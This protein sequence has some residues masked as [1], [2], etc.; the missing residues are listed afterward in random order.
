MELL[1]PRHKTKLHIEHTTLS[2]MGVAYPAVTGKCEKCRDIYV[3]RG[4]SLSNRRFNLAGVSYE[5][6]SELES[7]YPAQPSICPKAEKKNLVTEVSKN[8]Q[9]SIAPTLA[10]KEN[11]IQ[12]NRNAEKNQAK[13]VGS[14]ATDKITKETTKTPK[15]KKKKSK[16]KEKSSV[17]FTRWKFVYPTKE[18]TTGP[19]VTANSSKQ[20][21]VSALDIYTP[22]TT[23]EMEARGGTLPV[24]QKPTRIFPTEITTVHLASETDK[25]FWITI[26]GDSTLQESPKGILWSERAICKAILRAIKNKKPWV[27]YNSEP[28]QIVSYTNPPALQNCLRNFDKPI[29]TSVPPQQEMKQ[30]EIAFPQPSVTT[31]HKKEQTSGSISALDLV[32]GVPFNRKDVIL[33][34]CKGLIA[35]KRDN[36]KVIAATGLL[37]GRRNATA[38]IN[39]NYCPQCNKCFIGYDEYQHY[40]KQYKILIGNIR[41]VSNKAKFSDLDLAEESPLHLCG[42]S[43]SQS[44]GLTVTER[45]SILQY[46]MEYEIMQKPYIID[47]LNFFIRRNGSKAD[48]DIAVQKWRDDLD[49]VRNYRLGSQSMFQIS[50]VKKNR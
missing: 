6:M 14:K 37:A 29:T 32:N 34:I 45:R 44:V 21:N 20:R 43:V 46:M 47:Y 30:K 16:K 8:Q 41:L 13:N 27:Y 42:Y 33:Y 12:Q 11:E 48:M 22:E 26:V 50:G 5:V 25:H 10:V 23:A 36:H 28:C 38:K 24:P 7:A 35:C 39:I 18:T 15:S 17:L 31:Y 19:K 9:K 1:C 3:N 40:R 4:L 49:W 2:M